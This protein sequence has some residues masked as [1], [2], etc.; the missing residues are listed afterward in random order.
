MAARASVSAPAAAPRGPAHRRLR[1]WHEAVD[2]CVRCH[3]LAAALPPALRPVGRRLGAAAARVPA[4]IADAHEAPW[5]GAAAAHLWT[6]ARATTRIETLLVVLARLDPASAP[7]AAR[8]E[9]ACAG[10]RRRLRQRVR[11][12]RPPNVAGP[13]AV[14]SCPVER[15]P[16]RPVVRPEQAWRPPRI[17]PSHGAG[18]ISANLRARLLP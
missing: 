8:L 7:A 9:A 16:P 13:C 5:R 12:L 15:L 4:A 11:A 17:G 2:L 1:V 6:A 3:G 18:L 14:T 10:V